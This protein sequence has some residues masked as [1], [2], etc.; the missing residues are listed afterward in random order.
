MV[1]KYAEK[2]GAPQ[3]TT[4]QLRHSFG[5]EHQRKSNLVKTKEQLA[6]RSIETTEKYQVLAELVD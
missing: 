6:L 4:R 2:Y 1:K 5:L 3:L